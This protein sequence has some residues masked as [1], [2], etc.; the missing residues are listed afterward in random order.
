LQAFIPRKYLKPLFKYNNAYD[1]AVKKQQLEFCLAA[2]ETFFNRYQEHK[3][4][5]REKFPHTVQCKSIDEYLIN[6][7][8]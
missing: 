1:R 8:N 6:C 3:T 2:Q 7:G 4:K 5:M